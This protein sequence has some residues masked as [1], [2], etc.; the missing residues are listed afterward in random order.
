M[1]TELLQVLYAVLI[2][3]GYLL[4]YAVRANMEIGPEYTA[5]PRDAPPL[6]PISALCGRLQRA[7]ANHVETLPW[8]A[9]AMIVAHLAARADPWVVGAGWVYLAARVVYL[10][11]YATGVAFVRSIVWAIATS[12]ILFIILRVL[13]WQ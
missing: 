9:T 4:V 5:G 13:L 6:R 12:A 10:P 1:A 3:L 8:F 11:A 2:A 7:Y